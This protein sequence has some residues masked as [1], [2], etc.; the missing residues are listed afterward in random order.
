EESLHHLASPLA[1][2]SYVR[3]FSPGPWSVLPQILQEKT[4][5][6]KAAILLAAGRGQRFG[7]E[8]PKLLVPLS[9]TR[10]LQAALQPCLASEVDSVLVVLGYQDREV[11]ATLGP[12]DRRIHWIFAPDW[13]MGMGHSLAF[14]VNQVPK[15]CQRLLVGLADMPWLEAQVVNKL[16]QA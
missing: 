4:V 6:V 3:L 13:H 2:R 14:A 9:G 12:I 8:V 5:I 10:V 1:L 7:G 11:R 16:L 15:E